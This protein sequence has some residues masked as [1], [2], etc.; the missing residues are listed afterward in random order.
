MNQIVAALIII[1]LTVVA[2]VWLWR[3]S[4]AV[5][6][7]DPRMPFRASF[8]AYYNES[9]QIFYIEEGCLEGPVLVWNM[10]SLQWEEAERACEG[11]LVLARL[12]QVAP[13]LPDWEV[14]VVQVA[15]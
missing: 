6:A 10:T 2:G 12:D 14:E 5:E 13:G 4:Q 11:S 15:G 7:V 9:H 8:V 3:Q 1:A